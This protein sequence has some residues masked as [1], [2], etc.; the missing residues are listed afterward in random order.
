M[1]TVGGEHFGLFVSGIWKYCNITAQN[2]VLNRMEII[3]I[4]ISSG[5]VVRI[6]TE[7]TSAK[8]KSDGWYYFIV[9]VC[10]QLHQL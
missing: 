5:Q 9:D 1:S 2:V 4:Y 3:I 6:I 8:Y 7:L 10:T